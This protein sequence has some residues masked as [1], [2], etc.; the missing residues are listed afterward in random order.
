[1]ILG[2]VAAT[3][4]F[5]IVWYL[6]GRLYS[7]VGADMSGWL[8]SAAAS[9]I[10]FESII[11]KLIPAYLVTGITIGGLGSLISIRKHLKV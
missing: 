10:P 8:S 3:V 1:M 11:W 4:S 6:Y 9:L 5:L 2:A 7:A